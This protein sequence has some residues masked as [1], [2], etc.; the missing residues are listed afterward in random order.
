[1]MVIHPSLQQHRENLVWESERERDRKRERKRNKRASWTAVSIHAWN[2][3]GDSVEINDDLKSHTT[4]A[5]H[6]G[7]WRV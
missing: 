6:P 3:Q 4:M 1:M 7:M 2:K 5:P